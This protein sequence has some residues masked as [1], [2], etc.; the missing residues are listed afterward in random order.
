MRQLLPSTSS[1]RGGSYCI[2]NGDGKVQYG[3]A[4][5]RFSA[6]TSLP[7][8]SRRRAARLLVGYFR[9]RAA[10]MTLVAD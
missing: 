5:L 1:S 6:T 9:G 10:A 8:L 7:E 4:K 2:R 3:R